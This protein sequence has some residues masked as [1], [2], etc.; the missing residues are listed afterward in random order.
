MSGTPAERATAPAAVTWSARIGIAAAAVQVIGLVRWPL[1]VPSL[2]DRATDAGASP[3]ARADAADTFEL[4]GS[5]LGTGIG[6][7]LGYLLTALWT[8]L[9]VQAFRDRLAGRWFAAL[10]LTSAAL[11]LSGVAIPLDLPGADFANFA[12]YVLW[13]TW[14]IAFAVLLWRRRTVA[15]KAW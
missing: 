12:G 3:E 15:P 11:I 5:I 9:V 14:L 6:E 13:S 7:T 8:V 2:A 1:V 10:G 4:L